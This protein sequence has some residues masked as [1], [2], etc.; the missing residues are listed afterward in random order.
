MYGKEENCGDLV[1][2]GHTAFVVTSILSACVGTYWLRRRY[3][4]TAWF[5][6]AAY[7]TTFAGLVLASRKHYSVDVWLAIIV[8]GLMYITFGDSWVPHFFQGAL[9]SSREPRTHAKLA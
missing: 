9:Q 6:G 3:R 5:L 4:F 2:S 8:S 1:F 7:L